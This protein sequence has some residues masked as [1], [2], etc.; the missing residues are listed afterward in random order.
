MQEQILLNL[1]EAA[2]LLGLTAS[3]LYNLTRDRSRRRQHRPIPFVRLGKRLAFRR[4]SLTQW[5][6]ALEE[7]QA[8][9]DK[10]RWAL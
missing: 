5:A 2:E 6:A 8:Q 3:Q 4:D 10:A 9:H 1:S 7:H